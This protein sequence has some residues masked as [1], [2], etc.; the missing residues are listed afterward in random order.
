MGNWNPPADSYTD[1][2]VPEGN[3]CA[4]AQWNDGGLVQVLTE[5][6]AEST[7]YTLT[8]EVGNSNRY[9]WTG[10][11]VQLVAGGTEVFLLENFSKKQVSC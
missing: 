1:S 7:D 2:L 11:K 4:W 6:F 10:Y 5:T 9:D 8:V 3:M